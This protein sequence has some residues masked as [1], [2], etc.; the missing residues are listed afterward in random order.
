MNYEDFLR[1]KVPIAQQDGI[2]IEPGDV[3]PLLKPHQRAIVTWAVR[4]GRRAIFASFGLGK[5]LIQLET[6]RLTLA[7]TGGR[8][9]IV[10]PLGVRQEFTRDAALIGTPVRF[11]R[12]LDEADVDGIYLTNYETVRDAKLDPTAFQCV[13]LDEAACLRGFGGTKTFREF[14]ARFEGSGIPRFVATATP[15]PNEYIELAVYAAFLD[16]MDV[17][18]IKTRWF[19]RDSEHADALTLH[20]H[21]AAEFWAWVATWSIW[22]QAPSDLCRCA[23][24][25]RSDA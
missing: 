4:G 10:L 15:D 14:M 16:I 7:A 21:K 5:S 13:S 18:Q 25:G 12:R 9:L 8:G 6:V 3:H 19:K 1:A 17:G 2:Q 20:H 22:M 11:I 24:H 23:C